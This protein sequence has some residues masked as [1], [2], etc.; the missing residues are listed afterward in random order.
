MTGS[1][2]IYGVATALLA[3]LLTGCLP[4]PVIDIS[5]ATVRADE[6]FTAD[7]SGTIVSNVP[8]DTVVVSYRWDFGDGTIGR[9]VNATHTYRQP[10][11]YTIEL[12]VVDSAGREQSTETTLTVLPALPSSDSD[13]TDSGEGEND[14][15]SEEDS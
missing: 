10:G 1:R 8:A 13:T 12:T 11:N 9:G 4:I 3:I 15:N 14:E 7:G 2:W 6:S 5:P